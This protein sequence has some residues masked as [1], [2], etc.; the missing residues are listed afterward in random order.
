[1]MLPG[2]FCPLGAL[3]L[4]FQGCW[5]QIETG[6]LQLCKLS[7]AERTSVTKDMVSGALCKPYT[8]ELNLTELPEIATR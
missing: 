6:L 8:A 1:M 7:L 2:L 4:S 3:A 5:C